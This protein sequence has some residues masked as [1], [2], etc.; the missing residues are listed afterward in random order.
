VTGIVRASLVVAALALGS[1]PAWAQIDFSG[2]W[3]LDREISGDPSRATFEPSPTP[4]RRA[5]GGFSGGRGGR[6]GGGRRPSGGGA[7]DGRSDRTLTVDER[8]RLREIAEFVK[9]LPSMSIEHSDHSTFT[10]TDAHG[11]SRLFPTDRTVAPQAFTTVTVDSTTTWDGPHLVTTFR[12]GASRDLRFTYI[13]VPATRQLALRIELDESG[14]PR[15]DV[16]ELRL[17]YKLTPAHAT[18][19]KSD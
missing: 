4:A 19:P 10:I 8:T 12:I 16:P 6:M 14:R 5:L 18:T 9:G 13:L 7:D 17:V 15:A 1:V 2:A 11:R 3:V